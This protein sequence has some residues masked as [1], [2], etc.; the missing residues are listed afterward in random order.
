MNKLTK[1]IVLEY[2]AGGLI[3]KWN[4]TKK[5]FE[6]TGKDEGEYY[7]EEYLRK[8]FRDCLKAISY[9]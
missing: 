7:S 3:V 2:A 6:K 1:R 5:K 4:E 9:C 8:I